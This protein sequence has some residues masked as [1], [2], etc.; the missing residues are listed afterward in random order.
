MAKLAALVKGQGHVKVRL[1]KMLVGIVDVQ[2]IILH[3]IR[4]KTNP[5]H[6]K[7]K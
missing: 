5:K 7:I 1:T 6:F 3:T 4:C 2:N